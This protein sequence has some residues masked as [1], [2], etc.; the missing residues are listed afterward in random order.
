[1]RHEYWPQANIQCT[2]FTILYARILTTGLVFGCDSIST[3]LFSLMWSWHHGASTTNKDLAE[4]IVQ[5]YVASMKPSLFD[6]KLYSASL[7][8]IFIHL[9]SF[10]KKIHRYLYFHRRKRKNLH[11]IFPKLVRWIKISPIDAQLA[12]ESNGLV[13]MD[14]TWIWEMFSAKSLF[15]VLASHRYYYF[16]TPRIH[17]SLSSDSAPLHLMELSLLCREDVEFLSIISCG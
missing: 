3:W 2:F 14:G 7:G 10:Q 5:K 16:P 9:T 1:M 15:V 12:F 6:S 8:D 4:K 17:V 13:F 11:R